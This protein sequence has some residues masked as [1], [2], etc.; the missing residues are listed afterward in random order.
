MKAI[1]WA[2]WPEPA[3]IV[4]CRFPEGIFPEGFEQPGPKE[5]PVLVL[6]VEESTIDPA[7]C[8]VE[9]AYATSQ[10]TK[11]IYPGE[12]VISASV[13]SGLTKDT[14]FDLVNRH[15]L[16]F[17]SQWFGEAPGSKPPHPRRGK[18]DITDMAIKKRLIAAITAAE[19]L[20]KSIP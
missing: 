4:D 16:P 3:D 5:R 1:S 10:N 9:V 20:R 12:F 18:L 7:G 17:D 2:P 15:R 19:T 13:A 6:S 11:R 8:V 14:K